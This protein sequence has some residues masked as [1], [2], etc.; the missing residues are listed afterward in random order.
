MIY[1]REDTSGGDTIVKNDYDGENKLLK[2]KYKTNDVAKRVVDF[3]K[4]DFKKR[5]Y[6]ARFCEHG[7][8]KKPNR[9]P[10]F[11]KEVKFDGNAI[12]FENVNE[13]EV[14]IVKA[15]FSTEDEIEKFELNKAK[16]VLIIHYK[17]QKIAENI[18]KGGAIIRKGKKFEPIVYCFEE[19]SKGNF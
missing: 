3:G 18:I 13:D 9:S 17:N 14:E 19:K 15:L 7:K 12:M 8:E 11:E 10:N 6:I 5:T 16:K 1:S 4:V 2:I